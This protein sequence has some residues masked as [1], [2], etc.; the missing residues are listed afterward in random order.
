MLVLPHGMPSPALCWRAKVALRRHRPWMG[1]PGVLAAHNARDKAPELTRNLGGRFEI[2]E[3]VFKPAPACF[4]AQTPV[5]LA[6]E[7]GAMLPDPANIATI[8]I[9][10]TQAAF[11]YPGCRETQSVGTIQAATMSIAFGVATTLLAGRIDPL[12]W[13]HLHNP[14]ANALMQRCTIAPDADLSSAFP[15]RCGARI[16]VHLKDGSSK[17]LTQ[18]D[19]RS[20]TPT[21]VLARFHQDAVPLIGSDATAGLLAWAH[22]CDRDQAPIENSSPG[23]EPRRSGAERVTSAADHSQLTQSRL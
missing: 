19:F 10:V 23:S 1:H 12:A 4:F 7:I 15:A 16:A 6:A 5:Q 22:Q 13:Q 21:E 3:I 9:A 14:A 17:S 8:D 18:G 20:M 2:L 11:D